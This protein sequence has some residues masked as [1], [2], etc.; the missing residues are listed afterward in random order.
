L[1]ELEDL[2]NL[3]NTAF[4]VKTFG[5]VHWGITAEYLKQKFGLNGDKK[6]NGRKRK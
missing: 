5:N 4:Y 1:E 6:R 2:G 3:G